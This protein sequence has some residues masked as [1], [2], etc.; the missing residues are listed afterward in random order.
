MNEEESK[1]FS[2]C[3]LF[4]SLVLCKLYLSFANQQLLHFL[5]Y[6]NQLI[7]VCPSLRTACVWVCVTVWRVG[8]CGTHKTNKR[9]Q[10]PPQDNWQSFAFQD[11]PKMWSVLS[12]L[13][14]LQIE[15]NSEMPR[16]IS[17][18]NL[19]TRM[20]THTHALQRHDSDSISYLISTH[21]ATDNPSEQI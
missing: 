4:H 19:H 15:S 11:R 20:H 18:K 2:I 7:S 12:I 21:S 6:V 1:V 9:W 17:H 16:F 5:H 8:V 14:E 13:V 3:V 10:Q